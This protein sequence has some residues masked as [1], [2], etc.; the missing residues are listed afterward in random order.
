MESTHAAR[1]SLPGLEGVLAS[2]R[3]AAK[4]R[5]ILSSWASDSRAVANAPALRMLEDGTVL[6]I[7]AILDAL[8]SLDAPSHE[9]RRTNVAQLRPERGRRAPRSASFRYGDW[10]DDD[11]DPPPCPAVIAP[12][13]RLPPSGAEVDLQAA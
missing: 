10:G 1:N 8:K 11:D 2:D 13:P 4:K 6:G 3:S 7:D 5:E 12:V 9:G